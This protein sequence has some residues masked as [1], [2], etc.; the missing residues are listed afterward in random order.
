MV[1]YSHGKKEVHPLPCIIVYIIRHNNNN[2]NNTDIDNNPYQVLKLHTT[3][4][5]VSFLF[6]KNEVKWGWYVVLCHCA[7]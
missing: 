5:T 4:Y 2:N 1:K 3:S 7:L 6:N